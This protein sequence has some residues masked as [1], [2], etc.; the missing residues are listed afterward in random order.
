MSTQNK[1]QK[2]IRRQR[3]IR[4]KLSGTPERPRMHVSRSLVGMYIQLIDDV[5]SKTLASVN[6][7]KDLDKKGDAGERKGKVA[8]SYLLGKTLAEKAKQLKITTI[9][10]DRSGNRYHGRVKAAAEGARDGGLIF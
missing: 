3:K 4:A 7:K 5:N 8:E 6:F 10:F 9:V 1:L 2:K